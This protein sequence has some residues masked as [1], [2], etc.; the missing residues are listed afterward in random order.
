M[1]PLRDFQ[2]KKSE[3]LQN[4]RFALI[5][6]HFLSIEMIFFSF[7]DPFS[8]GMMSKHWKHAEYSLE[9]KR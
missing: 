3:M 2:T 8:N 9:L 4:I 6:E 1:G 5:N 7:S